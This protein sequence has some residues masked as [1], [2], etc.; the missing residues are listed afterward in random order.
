MP[1]KIVNDKWFISIAREGYPDYDIDKHA[2][3]RVN[4]GGGKNS[5]W[6]LHILDKKWLDDKTFLYQIAKIIQTE[7]PVNDIDWESTFYIV[8]KKE[9]I[10]ND[11]HS[12]S[13]EFLDDSKLEKYVKTENFGDVTQ[14]EEEEDASVEN[15]VMLSRDR[16]QRYVEESTPEVHQTI[17]EIVLQNL[18]EYGLPNNFERNL[19]K[20]VNERFASILKQ[21]KTKPI[22]TPTTQLTD[23][24]KVLV[25]KYT[26]DAYEDLNEGLRA[27]KESEFELYLNAVLTKL[28]DCKDLV[29]RGA[30]LT[31]AQIARYETAM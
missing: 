12:F 3:E 16:R 5:A 17:I 20:F 29:Y 19:A 22:G 25:Y 11:I 21:F 15:A 10:D 24:E 31:K 1:L 9:Y 6:I 7:R 27:G 4:E 26:L 14:G 23:H 13:K 2:M 18:K 30:A 8:E 28:P